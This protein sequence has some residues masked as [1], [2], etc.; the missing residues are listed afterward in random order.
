[1]TR[2]S[3]TATSAGTSPSALL[4]ELFQLGRAGGLDAMGVAPADPLLRARAALH[5]RQE[6]GLAAGMQFTYKN[7]DRSTE[8][9]RAVKGARSIVVG[10]R[11]Y[12]LPE[13]PAPTAASA[14]VA[15]YAWTDHYAPLRAALKTIALRLRADGHRAVVFAD[16]NSVVDREVAW[17]AGIGWFG[18]NANLLLPGRGSWFVLGC[19]ITDA[20]LPVNERTVRDGCGRCTRCLD[21]CPT[22]AI[23]APGVVDANRC[24]AWLLQR[25]GT[26]PEEYR[27]ALGDRL[28]G[29]DDCQEVCPPNLRHGAPRR[30]DERGSSDD[31]AVAWVPVV[32]LLALDDEEVIARHGSWYLHNREVRW[33]R[34]NALVVLGNVGDGDD[35]AVA[36]TLRRYLADPD[37]MLREHAAWAAAR[38]GRHDLVP[39]TA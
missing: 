22:G 9:S 8:P 27:V 18:K 35:A 19:V 20:E 32:E 4:D 5:E 15:R 7:P 37:P 3:G 31:G 34:R 21:D 10:A 28:Y 1:M 26:F 30:A 36:A 11:N 12:L 2:P 13:P 38:L 29:C 39:P 6:A 24:L 25:P 17:L 33:L 23:V 16:D 14:R